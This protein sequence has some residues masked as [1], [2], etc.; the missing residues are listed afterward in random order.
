MIRPRK[1]LNTRLSQSIALV[2]SYLIIGFGI[3]PMMIDFQILHSLWFSITHFV[4]YLTAF[5][6]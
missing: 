5:V 6:S 2:I 4:T 1:L 3:F